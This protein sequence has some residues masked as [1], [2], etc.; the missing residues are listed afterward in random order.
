MQRVAFAPLIP[1]RPPPII[2]A[3]LARRWYLTLKT[4]RSYSVRQASPGDRRLLAEFVVE[5]NVLAGRDPSA[6]H[7]LT[8]M[9]FDRVIAGPN[10][11]ALAFVA[12]ENS[13][14]ADR[15]IG[16]CA[17]APTCQDGA[18]FVVAV[19]NSYR[20]EQVGRTLLSTLLR[21]ARSVG[22]RQ[23]SGEMAWSNRAMQ[24]LATSVGFSVEPLP[25]DRNRRLLVLGLK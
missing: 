3:W 16:V 2:D 9:L 22:I 7:D 5:L 18:T 24:M 15:V 12:L 1:S 10:D 11:G 21:Q 25:R 23:L 6:I 4:Q 13:H 19:A 20:E 8:T 17:Y 14:G